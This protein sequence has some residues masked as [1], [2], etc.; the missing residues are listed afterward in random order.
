MHG[1]TLGQIETK[2]GELVERRGQQG[3]V[4]TVRSRNYA[5][6]GDPFPI[7]E[8]GT[9]GA[10]FAAVYWGRACCFASAGCFHDAPIDREVLSQLVVRGRQLQRRVG[11]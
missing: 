7:N 6:K 4:V 2:A 8:E 10:L 3:R 9:F 1:D 5:A 11:R